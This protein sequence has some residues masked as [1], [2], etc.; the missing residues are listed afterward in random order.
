MSLYGLH[1]CPQPPSVH[2]KVNFGNSKVLLSNKLG[3]Q[4]QYLLILWDADS[5]KYGPPDMASPSKPG[6]TAEPSKSVSI[7]VM[8]ETTNSTAQNLPSNGSTV[9]L[10]PTNG[11]TARKADDHAVISSNGGG[12]G[13]EESTLC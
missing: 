6:I 1:I 5:A 9:A 2:D 13:K 7:M 3:P 11:S 12:M 4:S 8:D 10:P